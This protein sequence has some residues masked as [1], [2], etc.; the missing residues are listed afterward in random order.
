M[1]VLSFAELKKFLFA[2]QTFAIA[3]MPFIGG[4]CVFQLNRSCSSSACVLPLLATDMGVFCNN[5]ADTQLDAP[6]PMHPLGR[7]TADECSAN[8]GKRCGALVYPGRLVA[9]AA[10]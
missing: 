6:K 5:V 3:V 7:R 4:A 1:C 8:A 2:I 10:D 9:P